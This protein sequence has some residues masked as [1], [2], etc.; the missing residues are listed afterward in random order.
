VVFGGLL[1][2]T[3]RILFNSGGVGQDQGQRQYPVGQ[4]S[5]LLPPQYKLS[6]SCELPRQRIVPLF[7]FVKEKFPNGDLLCLQLSHQV[8]IDIIQIKEAAAAPTPR[9]ELES[10]QEERRHYQMEQR[11]G[12]TRPSTTVESTSSV[13]SHS[14]VVDVDQQSTSSSS[15]SVREQVAGVSQRSWSSTV[16]GGA[17]ARSI[18]DL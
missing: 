5:G 6:E 16:G 2:I 15:S 11:Q 17:A 10:S 8:E 18:S 12:P 9:P 13:V 4:G 14:M 7:E 1:K 3:K